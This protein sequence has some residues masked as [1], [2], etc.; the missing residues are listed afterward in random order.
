MAWQGSLSLT[1]SQ[2]P[3]T[4]FLV[5]RLI[6]PR[7]LIFI[8][9]FKQHKTKAYEMSRS[10]FRFRIWSSNL[11]FSFSASSSIF[12]TEALWSFWAASFALSSETLEKKETE[13]LEVTFSVNFSVGYQTGKSLSITGKPQPI[14]Y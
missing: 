9:S 10:S 3:K 14:D 6:Y 12:F 5:A 7:S 2:T 13:Y 11:L 1:W 4:G 8:S